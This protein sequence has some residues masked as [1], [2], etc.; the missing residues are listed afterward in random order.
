MA[1]LALSD[2]E[3][4]SIFSRLCNP[5]EPHLAVYFS[6]ASH[7]LLVPTQALR[8]QLR[9]WHEAAA[10]LYHKLEMH[11]AVPRLLAAPHRRMQVLRCRG[12]RETT[13]ASWVDVGLS[14][15]NLATLATLSSVMPALEELRLIENL[16]TGKSGPDGV[17]RL[18]AGLGAGAL[19]AVSILQ[20]DNMYVGNTGA[21]ALGVALSRGALPRLK[22]LF[23]DTNGIG[24]AGLIALAPALR[25][26]P[27]LQQLVIVHNPIGDESLAALVAPPPPTGALSPPTGVLTKLGE[28]TLSYTQ[29]SDV[30]C[31]ALASAF[32]AGALPVCKKLH[33][34]GNSASAT[35]LAAVREA[36]G[37]TGSFLLA[38][39]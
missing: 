17:Q 35:A 31:A 36:L 2:D 27:E 14:A 6:S 15:A 12:L 39:Q 7:G 5:L 25:R 16:P 33:L 28:L 19:P 26:L 20:L 21:S 32:N 34:E 22:Q 13:C 8:Q 1:L 9:E 3:L 11:G 38:S 30:G 18:A 23:L 29:I 4:N 37:R 24:D 10:A